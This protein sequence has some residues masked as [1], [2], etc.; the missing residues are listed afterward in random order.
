MMDSWEQDLSCITKCPRCNMDLAGKDE[1]ILSVYDNEPICMACKKREEARSDYAQ[2]SKK[3][4]DQC[5]VEVDHDW[6]DPAGYC[7]HHFYPY[8]C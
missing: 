5:L 4:I 2:V 1:R 8:K 6:G 3:M 7:Y